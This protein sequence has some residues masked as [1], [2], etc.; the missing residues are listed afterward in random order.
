MR[1]FHLKDSW[2]GHIQLQEHDV[3]SP[4]PG[5]GPHCHSNPSILADRPLVAHC[6]RWTL[7]HL[8]VVAVGEEAILEW[9]SFEMG[10]MIRRIKY[11]SK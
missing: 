6:G 5:V 4:V 10:E 3:F 11:H 7:L 9:V 8:A 1:E 2:G